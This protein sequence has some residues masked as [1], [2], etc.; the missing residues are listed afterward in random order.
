MVEA[1]SDNHGAD[2]LINGISDNRREVMKRTL[3]SMLA[4]VAIAMTMIV[5]IT[6]AGGS[7]A[8]AKCTTY[9]VYLD[10]SIPPDCFP[11]TLKT[12]WGTG[13]SHIYY[14]NIYPGPGLYTETYPFGGA[15]PLPFNYAT[16]D[17]SGQV[18]LGGLLVFNLPCGCLQ[19]STGLDQ[20]GCVLIK[21]YKVSC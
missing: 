5:M 8:S 16:L 18:P 12:D 2:P 4:L 20:N 9:T 19:C 11:L 7:T 17:G 13:P 1:V 14:G 21:V 3:R 10:S 15:W 6:I